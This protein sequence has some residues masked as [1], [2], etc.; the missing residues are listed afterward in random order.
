MK[1]IFLIIAIA[2]FSLKG[3]SQE[4]NSKFKSIPAKDANKK[5]VVP[6][7][8]E[9]PK[10]NPPAPIEK[11][12]PLQVNPDELFKNTNLYKQESN[13]EGIFYRRNQF[14]GNF[15]TTAVYS[16]IMYR[17]AAFVD[18]DKVKVYFNDQVIEPEVSLT[19][20]FKSVKL[21]LVKGI[22]KI[23]IEALNEGFASPNTA[24]FKVYDDKGQVISSSEW[25]VGTGYKAVIVLVKE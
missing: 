18:G 8:E 12:A 21:N 25:N 3:F 11:P 14:L 6:P 24:E 19:S 23:D 5:E 17:D 13:V 1:K 9:A 10:E 2:T 4:L 22:N 20:D 16:T 7:K 15:N